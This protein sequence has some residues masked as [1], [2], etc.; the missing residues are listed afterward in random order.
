MPKRA[1]DSTR[2]RAADSSPA[3]S[4]DQDSASLAPP[5]SELRRV[6]SNWV[7]E[8]RAQGLSPRSLTERQQI[9]D[10]FCWW[11]ENAEETVLTLT[12]LTPYRLRAFFSY[13]REP[14]ADGRYGSD[15]EA[16][17]RDARPAT[18]HSYYCCL[19]GFVN[20]CHAE[21]V[22]EE[23]PLRN[24]RAPRVPRDQHQRSAMQP[25]HVE[26]HFC[27]ELPP[28]RRQPVRTPAVDGA[29]GLDGAAAVCSTGGGGPG[30]GPLGRE[31]S[32]PDEAEISHLHGYR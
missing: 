9:M 14:R 13:V 29:H 4:P 12:V 22:L 17:K 26:T 18:V 8:G 10:R 27:S 28:G 15:R 24:V 3:K 6:V 7:A 21:G 2:N 30:A 11:L 16:A 32:G 1:A 31:S 5:R 20:F 25:T 19:R 23:S